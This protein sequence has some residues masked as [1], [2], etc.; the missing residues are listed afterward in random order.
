MEWIKQLDDFVLGPFVHEVLLH[1][2]LIA[3]VATVTLIVFGVTVSHLSH[4]VVGHPNGRPAREPAVRDLHN[5]K[6][7]L[8]SVDCIV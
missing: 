4:G 2:M 8:S 3:A 5:W 6:P 7:G 1:V